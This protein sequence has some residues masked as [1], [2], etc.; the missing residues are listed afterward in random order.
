MATHTAA[1]QCPGCYKINDAATPAVGDE[2]D[3]PTKGD[4]SICIGC[5]SIGVYKSELTVAIA[6][7]DFIDFLMKEHP[8]EFITMMKARELILDRIRKS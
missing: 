1:W 7:Q 4:V 6:T 5:G 2:N 3:A 8:Q